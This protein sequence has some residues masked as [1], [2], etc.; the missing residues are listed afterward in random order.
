MIFNHKICLHT[1]IFT[2]LKLS[3][4]ESLSFTLPFY[5]LPPSLL[6]S[7]GTHTHDIFMC[8]MLQS[9]H[10][11]IFPSRCKI[12]VSIF[13]LRHNDLYSLPLSLAV[14]RSLV[15]SKARITHMHS[16]ICRN[17]LWLL[18]SHYFGA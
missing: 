13:Y 4:V 18:Y 2:I 6:P 1:Y 5:C 8:V 9:T 11:P 12:A 17:L 14:C 7:S 15:D 10:V 16:R 3:A